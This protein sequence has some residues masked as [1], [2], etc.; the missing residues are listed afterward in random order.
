MVI[1]A[2]NVLGETSSNPGEAYFIS[3]STNTLLKG[4]NPFVLLQ[5]MGN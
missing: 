4:M 3:H 5:A 1:D 2:G